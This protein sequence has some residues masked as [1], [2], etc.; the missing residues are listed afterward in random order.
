VYLAYGRASD[1]IPPADL[2]ALVLALAALPDGYDVALEVLHMRLHDD[3]KQELDP[4]L[5]ATGQEVLRRFSFTKKDDREDY[6]IGEIAR[7]CLGGE[8]GSIVAQELCAKLKDAVTTHA[9]Y[10]FYHGD[11]LQGLFLAQPF[12]SLNA[13]C[14]G[15]EDD[16]ARGMRILQDVR[17]RKDLISVIPEEELLRWC[18]EQPNTRYPAIAGVLPISHRTKDTDPLCWTALA[19]RFL[20]KAPDPATVLKKYVDQFTPHGGWSGSLAATLEANA[21]LLD[22][23]DGAAG[24]A[25]AV[26]LEKERMREAIER[27]R[28]FELAHDRE[29]DERFE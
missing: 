23:L 25:A 7:A 1:P 2:R 10:A 13:L 5:I 6:R 17:S 19:L 18:D 14:N 26:V 15:N 8:E 16:L 27:E 9:T 21:T 20:E 11:L 22:E 4:A 29:R 28:R 24:L 12:A 3:C